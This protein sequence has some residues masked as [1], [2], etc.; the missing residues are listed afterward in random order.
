MGLI[1]KYQLTTKN[2]CAC[3]QV[4]T[5]KPYL[6]KIVIF[7]LYTHTHTQISLLML[8]DLIISLLN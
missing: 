7:S 8:L 6:K 1:L 3:S 5:K 4:S 2:W